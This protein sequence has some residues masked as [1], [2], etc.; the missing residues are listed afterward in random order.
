MQ[1]VRSVALGLPSWERAVQ[2]VQEVRRRLLRVTAALNATDIGYAVVGGHAVAAWVESVDKAAVR[3]TPDVDV[4]L[5]R[6]DLRA[7]ESAL[8]AAGFLYQE[9][10]DGPLFLDGPQ[11]SPREAVHVLYAGEKVRPDYVLP[12]PDVSE[13]QPT[14]QFRVLSLEALV[15]MKLTSFRRKDQVHIQ[16]LISV[17]LIDA[18][19]PARFPPALAARL[20]ELLDDPNG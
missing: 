17:G 19:W 18:S 14:D 11:A 15:R 2:A 20:Q 4:L 13:S 1:P 10:H 7:A 9:T 3:N 5:C 12:N 16:D 8:A 6:S